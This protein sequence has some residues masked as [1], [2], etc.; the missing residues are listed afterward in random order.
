M[1]TD[2]ESLSKTA[3]T[4]WDLGNGF[5]QNLG[6]K[7]GIDAL[8]SRPTLQDPGMSLGLA[9]ISSPFIQFFTVKTDAIFFLFKSSNMHQRDVVDFSGIPIVLTVSKVTPRAGKDLN[10]A[11]QHLN[12]SASASLGSV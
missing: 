6:W 9:C 7:M 1:H 12:F 3:T 8:P 5:S 2:W 10:S 11:L 4:I